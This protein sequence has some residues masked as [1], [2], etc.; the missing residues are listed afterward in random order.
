[1]IRTIAGTD[2]VRA[3]YALNQHF[4]YEYPGPIHH[5]RHRLVVAPP[6]FYGD[7]LRISH[8]LRVEPDLP[9]RWIEDAFGNAVV[10][11]EAERVEHAIQLDYDAVIERSPAALP[12][13]DPS[14]VSDARYLEPTRLTMPSA[15]LRD[16][17][18]ALLDGTEDPG[19]ALPDRINS[20]VAG[21]MRY[22]SGATSVET[23]AAEAFARGEGVC[24][25]YAHVMLALCRLCNVPARYVSGHLLGE[26][27]THAWVEV[28]QA[29]PAPYY[30]VAI[31]YDPTHA[32]RT[33]LDYV[34]VAAGRDYTDV[35]P[36]SG[37]F[38]APY[39]GRFTTGRRVDVL[40]VE[41]AA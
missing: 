14:A 23:T 15:A 19:G 2:V 4:R 29:A 38:V 17:A 24:Q 27:G 6:A 21:H 22:V 3:S 8:R 12:Q 7:Q 13:V 35:A 26:G 41:Y 28:L 1:M 36:T 34:F 18:R 30:A 31:G 39:V 11:I 5:L 9:V 37:C 16:A 32:R 25:D 33:N 10:E 20:Y 40:D